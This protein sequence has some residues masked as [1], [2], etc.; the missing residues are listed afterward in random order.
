MLKKFRGLFTND[1]SIDL[2]TANTLIYVQSKGIVLN[3][4]S[5]VAVNNEHGRRNATG[6][7]AVGSQAK[8]MLGKAPKNIKVVRPM[9]DGVIA[10]CQYTEKMLEEYMKRIFFS[11]NKLLGFLKGAPRVLVCVPHGSTPVERNAIKNSVLRSGARDVFIITEPM[12]AA[13]GAGLPVREPKGSMVIDIGGGTTEVAIISLGD[14]VYANSVK[15]GGDKFDESIVNYI[16]EKHRLKIGEVTAEKI[17]IE[18]G[19]AYEDEGDE[20]RTMEVSGYSIIEQA[21]RSIVITSTEIKEALKNPIDEIILAVKKGLNNTPPE[22]SADISNEGM[23]ITGGGALLRNIDKVIAQ[24]TLVPVRIAEDPL[25]CVAR[26]G[27]QALEIYDNEGV[28]LF[29]Q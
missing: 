6:T 9:K 24:E 20:V 26:G 27:G 4:P 28:A 13:I 5:V 15:V 8:L 10:D 25:V 16:Q 23:V 17:K 22:S 14:I 19:C 11:S 7:I 29:D 2:G 12:A 1:L 21:P 3:E 18:I